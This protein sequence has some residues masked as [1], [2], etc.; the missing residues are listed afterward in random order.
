MDNGPFVGFTAAFSGT[1][2]VLDAEVVDAAAEEAAAA[3]SFSMDDQLIQI[4]SA[5]VVTK[6]Q[7]S[8]NE[9]GADYTVGD[10]GTLI[11]YEMW[12]DTTNLSSL[13]A[14]ATEILEYQFDMDVDVT[15]IGAFDFSMIAG[16]NFGFYAANPANSV[17]TF[18]SES[19]TIAV[20]S[21]IAI[22]DIDVTNDGPPSYIG[23]EK[24][25]G[26]FYLSAIDVN[27]TDRDITIKDM[28]V[29]T[30]VGNIFQDDYIAIDIV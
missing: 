9:Y 25:I 11:K 24:L 13:S 15:E 10:T 21:S 14:D 28:M 27:A 26:T 1:A 19:G 29:T 6:A 7:A 17:I 12:I 5:E 8:I 30:D 22:V 4:R 20:A 3:A 23:T 16:T 18:N 2:T